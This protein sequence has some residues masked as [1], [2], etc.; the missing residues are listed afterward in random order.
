[1]KEGI[2]Q[3]V[4]IAAESAPGERRVAMVPGA[5]S[6]VNKAGVQFI[7]ERGAGGP[8]GFPDSEYIEKGARIAD[9]QE[10]FR[11]AD[12]MVQVCGP[13]ANPQGGAEDLLLLRR[14]QTAIGFGE[15]LTSAAAACPTPGQRPTRSPATGRRGDWLAAQRI[16]PATG[17][18]PGRSR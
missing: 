6:V 1:M 8:A 12:V 18:A 2:S 14:G 16:P 4:G 9:R 10:V 3:I 13:G 7:V 11:A 17:P 5:M 15:P